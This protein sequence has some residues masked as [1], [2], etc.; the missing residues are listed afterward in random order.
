MKNTFINVIVFAAGAAIGVA[1]TQQYFKKK[2][3]KISQEEINSVKENISKKQSESTE[4]ESASEYSTLEDF[5]EEDHN[6]YNEI[7]TSNGYTNYSDIGL[8]KEK[9]YSTSEPYVVSP[10]EFGEIPEYS[11]ISLTYYA[12]GVLCNENNEPIGDVDDIVGVDS[13][14]HFGEYED[15]SVFV[16]NE[17]LRCDYEILMDERDYDDTIR[18]IPQTSWSEFANDEEE[19]I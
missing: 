14:T 13:L 7:L 8:S 5:D 15:D 1:A 11:Q 16:R 18:D 3:E 12:D 19:D 2:Y 17:R 10:D 6:N 4:E 9:E